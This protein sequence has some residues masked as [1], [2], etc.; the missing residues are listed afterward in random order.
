MPLAV[1]V[2]ITAGLLGGAALLALAAGAV[3]ARF[4]LRASPAAAMRAQE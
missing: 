4:A 3:T 2:A 1:P